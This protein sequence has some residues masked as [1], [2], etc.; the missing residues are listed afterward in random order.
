MLP[1]TAEDQSAALGVQ[2]DQILALRDQLVA[3]P[4]HEVSDSRVIG[5][6]TRIQA[7]INTLV[8]AR[9]LGNSLKVKSDIAV[10]KKQQELVA[11]A[12]RVIRRCHVKLLDICAHYNQRWILKKADYS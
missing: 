4:L 5:P 8:V 11:Q 3:F 9:T 12:E 1:Q 10:S 2:F 7:S 6:I